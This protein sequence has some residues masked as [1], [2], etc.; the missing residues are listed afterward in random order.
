MAAM[1]EGAAGARQSRRQQRR[2]IRL[3]DRTHR[4]QRTI[5][6]SPRMNPW[7]PASS[8]PTVVA[9]HPA[10]LELRIESDPSRIAAARRAVERYAAGLGFHDVA[11]GQLGLC[12][13][14]ALANVMRHAYGGAKDQPILITAGEVRE[15]GVI[16][17]V[18]VTIR[19]WGN[20]VNPESLPPKPYDPLEPG[21]GGLI[22]LQE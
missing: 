21:R 5:L 4:Q 12:V 7:T 11:Q 8:K 19:D 20:G 6:I 2:A 1:A 16:A 3:V 13:N 22:C 17:A 10:R 18:R 14:E 9:G 15:N